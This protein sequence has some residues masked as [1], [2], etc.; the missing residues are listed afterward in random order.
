[1]E[2][3]FGMLGEPGSVEAQAELIKK[4]G[5]LFGYLAAIGVT[6]MAIQ[7]AMSTAF[8]VLFTVLGISQSVYGSW[9]S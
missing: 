7:A 2:Y 5:K 4:M 6:W 9:C 3:E 1:M 8:K